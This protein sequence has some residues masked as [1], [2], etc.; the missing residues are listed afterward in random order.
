MLELQLADLKIQQ[1]QE[2]VAQEQTQ[3]KLYVK[4]ISQLLETEKSLR[5]QLASDR[6]R[7]QEFQV[8]V[9]NSSP[10]KVQITSFLRN[11]TKISVQET[12]QKSNEVFDTFNKEMAKVWKS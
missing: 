2:R 10:F 12:M 5:L 4:Q 7:F 1:H 11:L 9:I 3:K 6:Q 8:P